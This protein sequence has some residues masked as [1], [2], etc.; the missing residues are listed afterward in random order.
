[1]RFPHW[2]GIKVPTSGADLLFDVPSDPDGMPRQTAVDAA[3]DLEELPK[4]SLARCRAHP[5]SP[6]A[7]SLRGPHEDETRSKNPAEA[8]FVGLAVPNDLDREKVLAV[9][10]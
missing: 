8:D 10:L 7:V 3:S 9:S 2:W 1:M 4:R 5:T 6:G